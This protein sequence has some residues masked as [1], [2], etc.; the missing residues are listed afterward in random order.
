MLMHATAW[1]LFEPIPTLPFL[2]VFLPDGITPVRRGE[3][4]LGHFYPGQPYPKP[5]TI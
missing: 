5:G 1:G 4:N 2:P 3:A